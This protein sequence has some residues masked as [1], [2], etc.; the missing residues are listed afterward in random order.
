LFDEKGGLEQKTALLTTIAHEFGHAVVEA[1][2]RKTSDEIKQALHGEY[3]LWL[4]QFETDS[5]FKKV[6]QGTKPRIQARDW[7]NTSHYPGDPELNYLLSF[8]EYMANQ[9]ARYLMNTE[10]GLNLVES[11]STGF[12]R[13]ISRVL[14]RYYQAVKMSY[15]APLGWTQFLEHIVASTSVGRA[16]ANQVRARGRPSPFTESTSSANVDPSNLLAAYN[17]ALFSPYFYARVDG[18][19]S[20]TLGWPRAGEM[21]M[22]DLFTN[23]KEAE[24]THVTLDNITFALDSTTISVKK[25]QQTNRFNWA[26]LDPKVEDIVGLRLTKE[27]YE[28][29]KDRSLITDVK[30]LGFE[31]K[32]DGVYVTLLRPDMAIP[33]Q[34]SASFNKA[35]ANVQAMLDKVQNAVGATPAER[36]TASTGKDFYGKGVKYLATII[37]LLKKNR[38]IPGITQYME[39]LYAW[40]AT[41]MRMITRADDRIKAWTKLG[42]E[43]GHRLGQLLFEMNNLGYWPDEEQMVALLQKHKLSQEAYE[44]FKEIQKDFRDVLLTMEQVMISE[45]SKIADLQQR[46][47][48]VQAVRKEFANMRMRPYFPLSRFGK[49][50]IVMRANGPILHEGRMFKQ[51]EVIRFEA[52]ENQGDRDTRMQKLMKDFTGQQIVTHADY[53]P[54]SVQQFRGLPPNFLQMIVDK[55]SLTEEQK[56]GIQILMYEQAPAQSF[57]HHFQ[58]RANVP[59]YSMDAMRSYGNYFFHAANNIARIF[60]YDDFNGAIAL[61]KEN[62]KDLGDRFHGVDLTRR[63]QIQEHL[64][65]HYQYVMNPQ[66]EWAQL[67]SVA[68]H[69]YLGF[70]VRSAVVNLT[71][72]PIAT[73]SHLAALYSDAGAIKELARSYGRL[74]QSLGKDHMDVPEHIMKVRALGHEQGFLDES[75]AT[76][77]AA[78]SEGSMLQRAIAGT[79]MQRLIRGAGYYGSWLFHH[80]EKINRAVT[81]D[82]AYNL[83]LANPNSKHM[84]QIRQDFGDTI[85]QMVEEMDLTIDQAAAFIQA[86]DVVTTTQGEYARFNRPA[87]MRGRRGVIFVFKMFMQHMLWLARYEPGGKRYLLIML[88]LAG[89]SGAPFADDIMDIAKWLARMFGGNLDVRKEI[90]SFVNALGA[91]PDLIMHGIARDSFGMSQVAEMFGVPFPRVDLSGSLSMGRVIPGIEG[92]T[93]MLTPGEDFNRGMSEATGDVLGAGMNIVTGVLQAIGDPTP[94]NFKRFERSLPIALRGISRSYRYMSEGREKTRGGATIAKFSMTDPQQAAEAAAVALG[95]TPTRVSQKWEQVMAQ[96]DAAK[97]FQIRRKMLLDGLDEARQMKDREA[98]AD[99]KQD[100]RR[101]NKEVPPPLRLSGSDMAQSGKQRAKNRRVLERGQAPQRM[102]RRLYKEVEEDYPV[103]E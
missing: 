38:H 103:E 55:L 29:F 70:M 94:N 44:V 41:R 45:T 81:F 26:G 40:S 35:T 61:L 90:R 5:T 23:A 59:G 67:R 46:S 73:Y 3:R 14:K 64:E 85:T 57:R 84:V 30:E 10:A 22:N 66:N 19:I 87:L 37:Q 9:T 52:F 12:F 36:A 82:A 20:S 98:Y 32:D 34:V 13:K 24:D 11:T 31:V 102:F 93:D 88:G 43:Q 83:A 96:R 47:L 25:D 6:I 53:I 99:I 77:L 49:Y 69:W 27:A 95:F 8:V 91:D 50:T 101:Y 60:H 89:L 18:K 86:R 100:I 76:E 78:V 62:M 72:V 7:D 74:R 16:V 97:Y 92:A 80:A 71:Q 75:Q 2:Y 39:T 54:E 63:R 79:P 33:A 48:R 21:L 51:G 42:K 17:G 15:P 28:K 58:K 56:K 68:F 4:K 65:G 1:E